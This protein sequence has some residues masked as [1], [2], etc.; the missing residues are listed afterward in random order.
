[1]EVH[2]WRAGGIGDGISSEQVVESS[3]FNMRPGFKKSLK[4]SDIGS[5]NLMHCCENCTL[6]KARRLTFSAS[7]VALGSQALVSVLRS[8]GFSIRRRRVNGQSGKTFSLVCRINSQ[9]CL[10]YARRPLTT[11]WHVSAT[12][13]FSRIFAFRCLPSAFG[14]SSPGFHNGVWSN[15]SRCSLTLQRFGNYNTKT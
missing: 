10:S 11:T 3:G 14:F 5:S 8:R 4:R 7:Q 1:M 12:P 2:I 6:C 13:L 9:G 15:S